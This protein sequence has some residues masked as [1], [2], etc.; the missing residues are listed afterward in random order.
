DPPPAL[1]EALDIMVSK[2]LAIAE[3]G[4]YQQNGVNVVIGLRCRGTRRPRN[5]RE[6]NKRGSISHP[7]I[8]QNPVPNLC[9]DFE[10]AQTCSMLVEICGDHHFLRLRRFLEGAKATLTRPL[11]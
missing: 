7:G 5:D 4:P 10:R 3:T 2:R 6:K 1:L 9:D 11:R 8:L